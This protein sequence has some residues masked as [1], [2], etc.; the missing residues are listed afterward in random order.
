MQGLGFQ[1]GAINNELG[2]FYNLASQN[3]IPR[4]DLTVAPSGL[5]S[6]NNAAYIFSF[7]LTKPT[8]ASPNVIPGGQVTLGGFDATVFTGQISWCACCFLQCS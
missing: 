8:D 5:K 6:A 2:V 7:S 4:T 3:L 1:E